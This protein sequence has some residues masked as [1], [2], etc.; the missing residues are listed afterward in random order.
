MLTLNVNT[1][2]DYESEVPLQE[3]HDY[4]YKTEYLIPY[5][6]YSLEL[7]FQINKPEKHIVSVIVSPTTIHLRTLREEQLEVCISSGI[8]M[9]YEHQQELAGIRYHD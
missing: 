4:F 3:I 2:Y 5:D 7:R 9:L 1:T 6:M 8:N